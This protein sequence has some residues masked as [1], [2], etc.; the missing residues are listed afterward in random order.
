MTTMLEAVPMT[1]KKKRSDWRTSPRDEFVVGGERVSFL[2][3]LVTDYPKG[4]DWR[5]CSSVGVLWK[6]TNSPRDKRGH[7]S[8]R[9]DLTK[10][11]VNWLSGEDVEG[12]APADVPAGFSFDEVRLAI[13]RVKVRD[14][15]VILVL[16]W[17]QN[18][19]PCV[20]MTPQQMLSRLNLATHKSLSDRLYKAACL[21]TNEVDRG[22]G[23]LLDV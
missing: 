20:G 18:L 21:I 11:F 22:R 15:E 5:P 19:G 13:Q 10:R 23:G 6:L 12:V 3:Y 1:D 7:L 14:P 2:T 16:E 9:P 4:K 8:G 17:R